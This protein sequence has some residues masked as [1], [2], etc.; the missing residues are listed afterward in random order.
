[1]Q[2]AV[3]KQESWDGCSNFPF[4]IQVI[5]ACG[6]NTVLFSGIFALRYHGACQIVKAL[7]QQ[8]ET[9]NGCLP[10]KLYIFFYFKYS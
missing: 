1:M 7:L 2:Q 10:D 9:A 3:V 8:T 5:Q 4:G 6:Y